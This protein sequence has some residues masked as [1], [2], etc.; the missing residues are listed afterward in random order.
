ME[1]LQCNAEEIMVPGDRVRKEFDKEKLQRLAASYLRIGQLQPGVCV[2]QEGRYYLVAGE[3]RLRACRIAKVPFSFVLRDQADPRLLLEIE[4]EEN[5][6]R[7]NLSWQEEVEGLDRLH[8]L[9]QEQ[10]EVKGA[11]QS[12]DDTAMEVEKSRASVHRD[13]E[14]AEW[15]REFQEVKDA[16]S[17]A[18]A[19]KIIK[20]YKAELLRNQLLKE[21]LGESK[22]QEIQEGEEVTTGAKI[23]AVMN[24]AGTMIPTKLLIEYDRRIIQGRMESEIAR[25][26]EGSIDLALF[27]PPWGVNV[28]EIQ[29][30]QGSTE[31]FDDE[32]ELFSINIEGWLRLLYEKMAADSHLYLFFGI[33]NHQL[34]YD[35]LDRVG[36][37][38]NRMP[39]IW[40]KQGAH[41]TRNP[42]I[43][44]GRSYEPIAFARKGNKKLI[45]MGSPD[46]IITPAPTPAMKQSHPTAKHPD[47]YL[48]IIKRSAYPGDTVLDPMCG[49]GMA[50][51]AAETYS[52]SK[53]LDWWMIE[54][55]QSFR[56]LALENV[57]KGYSKV[58]N[59]EPI[60]QDF[61]GHSDLE[62]LPQD[63]RE[64]SPGT[65]EWGRYW[66]ERPDKQDEMLEWKKEQENVQ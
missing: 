64:L 40:Y 22:E 23:E 58:I 20:R 60:K 32:P 30:I 26:K 29:Q 28:S 51:V 25:F 56:E 48:E 50:A 37:K 38:T 6:N 13:L 24:V 43:W 27:D 36:F 57:I 8:R 10:E 52:L 55:K 62:S 16:G 45:T 1:I 2:G 21:A 14:L 33:I 49:S 4:I 54:E 41:V 53:K 47:I 59:R 19:Y 3:R 18:E 34:V 63:F 61:I 17:K 65:D 12:L 46:V 39:L 66:K 9:R 11:S 15:A 42:E 44:H 35:T 5:L 31:S 7:E